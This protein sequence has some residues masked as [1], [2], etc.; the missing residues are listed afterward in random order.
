MKFLRTYEKTHKEQ[1]GE[2]SFSPGV[3]PACSKQRFP[4]SRCRESSPSCSKSS[5]APVH[6]WETWCCYPAFLG[7]R[8][9]G[10]WDAMNRKKLN[11]YRCAA[12]IIYVLYYLQWLYKKKKKVIFD[13]FF[14][15][16]DYLSMEIIW[17]ENNSSECLSPLKKSQKTPTW[18][19][20]TV[21]WKGLVIWQFLRRWDAPVCAK[22]PLLHRKLQQLTQGGLSR[23]IRRPPHQI[24]S[25]AC[26]M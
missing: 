10:T 12:L 18:S 9:A 16:Q 5:L 17:H 25:R 26:A 20:V 14:L 1:N 21:C 2:Q 8:P 4:S 19:N 6:P 7:I 23:S 11:G 24:S 13:F 22:A 3:F 15:Q